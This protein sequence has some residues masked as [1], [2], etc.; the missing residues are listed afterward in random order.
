MKS[1]NCIA[2]IICFK[3]QDTVISDG[4]RLISK[5]NKT[6][7]FG[8]DERERKVQYFFLSSS[9][10][11]KVSNDEFWFPLSV[12]SSIPKMEASLK[13]H[14]GIDSSMEDPLSIVSIDRTHYSWLSIHLCI[15]V[16]TLY[17]AALE[18]YF[19]QKHE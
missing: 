5:V 8:A 12:G 15:I 19:F 6:H 10:I 13:I 14:S 11:H 2:E 7:S 4:I 1:Y 16:Y 9:D 17:S 18:K 3:N